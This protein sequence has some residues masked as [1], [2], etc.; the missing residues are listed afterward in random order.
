PA[1]A[2]DMTVQAQV[3]ALIADLQK[4]LD[5]AVLLIT[6]D[7]AVVSGFAD[8]IIVLYA[9]RVVE[10]GSV[11]EVFSDPR[12]PYTRGLLAASDW[13]GDCSA[14][15]REIPGIVPSLDQIGTGCAF[16]SR[17]Q[18]VEARCRSTRPEQVAIGNGR[19]AACFVAN[20]GKA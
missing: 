3:L 9:G 17:C 10:E 16:A 1:T 11:R 18:W 4:R 19:T 6:H 8:R 14:R 7:L 12:H 5:M 2:L 15:L 20:E 13:S